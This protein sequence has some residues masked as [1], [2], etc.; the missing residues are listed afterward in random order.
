MMDPFNLFRGFSGCTYGLVTFWHLSFCFSQ[1]QLQTAL[2][3]RED[4]PFL[5]VWNAPTEMCTR[6]FGLAFNL[7]SFP[8]VS[9]TRRSL[10]QQDV[11][12]FFHHM[13]GYYPHYDETTGQEMDGGIPQQVKM[14]E[15]LQKAEQDIQDLIPSNKSSGLAVIDWEHW[16]PIWSRNWHH[17]LI[18]QR[19]SIELVQQ[20]DLSL[21]WRR[22]ATI[23]MAQFEESAKE[24]L[25]RSLQL[26]KKLRPKQL[27]GYY[28]FPNCYNYLHKNRNGTYTG[29][30]PPRAISRNNELLWLWQESTALYPSIY[31]SRIFKSSDNAKLFV[32]NRVQEAMRVA[33]L[34][35][36]N[37]SLPVYPYTRILY[38]NSMNETLSEA[39]L[40][41]TIGESASLGAAGII[42]WESSNRT[43]NKHTCTLLQDLVENTLNGYILNVTHAARLCSWV[44]C[45][46]KGRCLRKN[47]ES[48]DYLHLNPNNFKIRRDKNG[49]LAVIG[50]ASLKDLEYMS[51]KFTCQCY[52]GKNCDSPSPEYWS[53]VLTQQKLW[54]RFSHHDPQLFRRCASPTLFQ[55]LHTRRE[56]TV[57]GQITLETGGKT[58]NNQQI[59]RFERFRD[60]GICEAVDK[61]A[62]PRRS[63]KVCVRFSCR[64]NQQKYL[65]SNEETCQLGS[66]YNNAHVTFLKLS[67]IAAK[68]IALMEMLLQ[69]RKDFGM[70][71]A[72]CGDSPQKAQVYLALGA[73]GTQGTLG[74]LGAKEWSAGQSS[75]GQFFLLMEI[76]YHWLSTSH[77]KY[78]VNPP[79]G[80]STNN[81]PFLQ[82]KCLFI[83]RSPGHDKVNYNSQ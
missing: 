23:A 36:E 40:V 69:L 20:K 15:H 52:V 81:R 43:Q 16:R 32:Q 26:G 12:I 72:S 70:G 1:P 4:F 77:L 30:C 58:E 19:Q 8:I 25:L 41:S 59:G 22:A 10:F 42:V 9:T 50:Q 61:I 2:P 68:K 33:T 71:P 80:F 29:I 35:K 78:I 38:R 5:A 13:F 44:L 65:S 34:S 14:H 79:Y 3:L 66:F 18:Y 47:W 83:L 73:L 55:D 64:Q 39:D 17:K 76:G 82:D 51:K 7:T 48:R 37:Y 63:D 75:A 46:N 56:R 74:A 45:R 54:L 60:F 57:A 27:W 21:T 11:R 49:H 24:F 67:F 6:K 62:E 28:L 53:K 31:L